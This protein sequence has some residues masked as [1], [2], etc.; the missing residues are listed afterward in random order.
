MVEDILSADDLNDNLSNVSFKIL[1]KYI[2][3]YEYGDVL[4]LKSWEIVDNILTADLD[5][6]FCDLKLRD[7]LF[8][9]S[10]INKKGDSFWLNTLKKRIRDEYSEVNAEIYGFY[11][12]TFQTIT[13]T[14]LELIE[15]SIDSIIYNYYY[16]KPKCS[17]NEYVANKLNYN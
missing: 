8:D 1:N 3:K 15:A 13:A 17:F 6:H 4:S 2:S 9:N 12:Y 16:S 5:P 7:W 10:L 11:F 14:L